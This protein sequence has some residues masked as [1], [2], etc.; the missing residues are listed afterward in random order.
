MNESRSDVAIAIN[1]RGIIASP[2]GDAA[3]A[4][5]GVAAPNQ[6]AIAK[7]SFAENPLASAI[8]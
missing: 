4:Y 8:A 2:Q 3:S 7:R 1:R 6:A 5:A